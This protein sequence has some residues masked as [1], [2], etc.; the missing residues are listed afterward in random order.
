MPLA[1]ARPPGSETVMAEEAETI[2]VAVTDG[3]MFYSLPLT[4]TPAVKGR[5]ASRDEAEPK[6]SG[7]GT[8]LILLGWRLQR[9]RWS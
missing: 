3:A 9:P 1:T 5:V 2:Y 6:I 4:V 8:Q 7:T